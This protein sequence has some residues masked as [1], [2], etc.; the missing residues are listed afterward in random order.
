MNT[1]DFYRKA[2]LSSLIGLDD[3]PASALDDMSGL[4]KFGA[5]VGKSALDT[6]RGLQQIGSLI[7]SAL[8]GSIGDTAQAKYD[9]LKA[10]QTATQAQDA[11]LMHTGAGLTGDIAGQAL[12][13]IGGGVALKGAGLLGSVIPNS[14]RAAA[15]TGAAQGLLQPISQDQSELS[16][17]GNG[18][19]GAGAGL[20]G[21]GAVNVVGAGLRGAKALISP[22]FDSGQDAIVASGLRR[23]G[24]DAALNAT[25]SHVPGVQAT[26]AEQTGDAGLAQ[27]QRAVADSDPSIARQFAERRASNNAGRLN[28]LQQTAGTPDDI[29]QAVARRDDL[30]NIRYQQAFNDNGSQQVARQWSA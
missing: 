12:Q 16:R 19:I 7:G 25:P 28:L 4:Q 6:V 22:F 29:A 27:L 2:G 14:Y 1:A 17:A 13:A 10:D 26:L 21:Q 24:G 5:G 30:A 18:A 20:L 23:F 3:K 9:Q 11:P 8:P 15:A